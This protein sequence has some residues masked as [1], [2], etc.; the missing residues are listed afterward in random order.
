VNS[1]NRIKLITGLTLQGSVQRELTGVQ[2][3]LVWAALTTVFC[4]M[5]MGA[6]AAP[7]VVQAGAATT[8]FLDL[9]ALLRAARRR[10]RA[11]ALAFLSLMRAA[12]LDLCCLAFRALMRL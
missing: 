12:R 7:Q 8:T 3:A 4:S 5:V 9:L 1:L 10:L 11:A 2:L 6:A